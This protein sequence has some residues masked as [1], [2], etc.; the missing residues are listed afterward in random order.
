[1]RVAFI[2]HRCGEEVCGGAELHCLLVAARMS[3]YWDVE[4]L[5]TCAV[6]DGSWANVYAP[7][8]TVVRG[9]PVRRFP[10][11]HPRDV[12]RLREL[13]ARVYAGSA[14]VQE[15]TDWMIARGPY[16]TQLYEFLGTRG[17]DYDFWIF[18][19]YVHAP[20]VFGIPLLPGRCALVPT[21][22]DEPE[23]YV[24]IFRKVFR[25]VTALLFSTPTEQAFVNHLFGTAG[26][27]QEVVGVGSQPPP[28]A[29][30]E[31]FRRS[32]QTKLGSRPFLLYAGR[33]NER[34]GSDV[35]FSYFLRFCEE[36][37][38]HPLKLVL[39]G[40]KDLEIPDDPN[41]VY[42]GY[43]DEREKFDAFDAA[44][45]IVQPSRYE[46]LSMVAVE[47][48]QLEKPVLVNGGCDVLRDQ[49]V[50]SNG[51]LWYETYDEFRD[52]LALLIGNQELRKRLGRSGREFVERHYAWEVIE[53]KYLQ[54]V[55]RAMEMEARVAGDDSGVASAVQ[56]WLG[57]DVLA[58]IGVI[59]GRPH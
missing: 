3:K 16:S 30:G 5:T 22:H 27:V 58:R 33:I 19:T 47:A 2:V 14:S 26:V 9:V 48:W 41:V 13:D 32:H 46:S 36:M 39:I 25:G 18:F 34:K 42:L 7:G 49:C 52:E 4:V 1:M 59:R 56:R 35:L 53:S 45:V 31:R 11:D 44:A 17:G 29:N 55:T 10:V 40:S 38:E 21:A 12:H 51:G 37:P 43:V 8:Q 23:I 15:Q 54:V 24:P 50:R 6:D 57:R 28:G 20:A